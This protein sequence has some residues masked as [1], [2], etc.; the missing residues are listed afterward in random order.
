MPSAAPPPPAPHLAVIDKVLL[1]LPYEEWVA[2]PQVA[3]CVR[4]QGLPG[5]ALTTVV[6]TGRRRGV[7]L[8]RHTAAES[9]VKRVNTQV[10]RPRRTVS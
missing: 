10:R 1:S 2:M 8:V 5:K 6:R 9:E 4:A 3:E 7:L